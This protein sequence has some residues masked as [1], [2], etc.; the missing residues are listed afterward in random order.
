MRRNQKSEERE[1]DE[2]KMK[3]AEAVQMKEEDALQDEEKT[4]VRT[5]ISRDTVPVLQSAAQQTLRPRADASLPRGDSR[6]P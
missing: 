3:W 4:R 1:E 6:V 2:E 5:L